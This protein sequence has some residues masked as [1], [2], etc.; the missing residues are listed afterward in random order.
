VVEHHGFVNLGSSDCTPPWETD[1]SGMYN[2]GHT[3]YVERY[4][5]N[6]Q[7]GNWELGILPHYVEEFE[8]TIE[9]GDS[10]T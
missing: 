8:Y 4:T 3:S 5:A 1:S 7:I 9:I 10:E 6:G 2:E